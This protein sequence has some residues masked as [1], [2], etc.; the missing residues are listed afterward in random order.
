MF[1]R[2]VTVAS[3][4]AVFV[5]HPPEDAHG[6]VNGSANDF[7]SAAVLHCLQEDRIRCSAICEPCAVQVIMHNGGWC[8]RTVRR[9]NEPERAR[10]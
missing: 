4:S 8:V 1:M 6:G 5:E 10:D 2:F 9:H 3:L 7:P